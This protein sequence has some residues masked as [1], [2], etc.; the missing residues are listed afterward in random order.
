MFHGTN[1]RIPAGRGAFVCA[2]E[3]GLM[4]DL[5]ESPLLGICVRLSTI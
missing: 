1:H 4:S 3:L 2:V 5:G